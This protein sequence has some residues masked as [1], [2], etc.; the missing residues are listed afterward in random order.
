MKNLFIKL[1]YFW[2]LFLLLILTA[3]TFCYGMFQ[4]GFV[5]WFLFYSFLPF[6]VYSLFLALYPLQTFT[7]TR[8]VNQEQF[9]VGEKLVAKIE[10]K[11]KFPF[12]LFYLIVEDQLPE[13]LKSSNGA[14][15]S[16]K[17]LLFPWFKRAFHFKYELSSMPRGEH[18]FFS[19]RLKTG[20]IFGLLEKEKEFKAEDYFLVYPHYEELI[21]SQK[22]KQF[23]QGS[24]KSSIR[25]LQDTTMASG[26]RE[27][28]AGDR[29]SWIDWKASARRDKMMTKEF[30][31]QRSQDILVIMDRSPSEQF[32]QVVTFTASV[33]RAVL[34]SGAS[35]GLI[36][37]GKENTVFPFYSS[38][39]HLKK[40]FYHL[41]KVEADSS[42]TFSSVLDKHA[43]TGSKGLK[44]LI[45][46]CMSI[47]LVRR[48]ETAPS[49]APYMLFLTK[50]SHKRLTNE[51]RVLV[52]RLKRQK[53]PIRIVVEGQ[54]EDAFSKVR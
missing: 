28:E 43:A 31:Q 3:I 50:E 7:V 26:V 52:E 8:T 35:A 13:K 39:D 20:D 21:Y 40:V 2:K 12:P 32:E 11:R 44:I 16:P 17:K 15:S 5:S 1:R 10:I 18:R 30:E 33:I 25:F 27:Y 19:I 22:N 49:N 6:A 45:T 48:F 29:F 38:E 47:E 46:S 23:E 42:Q 54:Y 37:I 41:A 9:S 14:L 51:E 53:I 34:K 4:G 24:S 36:S